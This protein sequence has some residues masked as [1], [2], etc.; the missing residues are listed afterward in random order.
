MVWRLTTGPQGESAQA[1]MLYQSHG[2]ALAAI[3][4]AAPV[5]GKMMMG[6]VF[7]DGLLLC[8]EQ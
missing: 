4:V 2:E 8:G 7:D 1:S 5:G 6:S 3:S